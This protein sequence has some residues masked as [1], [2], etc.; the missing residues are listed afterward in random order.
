MATSKNKKME[1]LTTGEEE[2]ERLTEQ[3]WMQLRKN[4]HEIKRKKQEG[5]RTR[6]RKEERKGKKV[7]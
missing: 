5:R 6:R 7:V 4:G 2:R 3:L 1:W